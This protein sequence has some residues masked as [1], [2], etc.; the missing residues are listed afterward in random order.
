MTTGILDSLMQLFAVFAAGRSPREAMLGRQSA[1]RYLSGRLSRALTEDYL[2]RYDRALG[3]LNKGM[4]PSFDEVVL[5]KRTSKLS[6]KLL[7]ICSRIQV[8][9]EMKDRLVMFLRLAEF[10]RSSGTIDNGDSFLQGVSD[11]LNLSPVDATNLKALVK[12]ELDV[13]PEEMCQYFSMSFG[14]GI[15]SNELI[16]CRVSLDDMFFIKYLGQEEVRLNGQ[17]LPRAASAPMA[18]G[19]VIKD[20]A[21]HAIFFSDVLRNCSLGLRNEIPVSFAARDVAHFFAYPKEQA[22]RPINLHAEQGELIGIM[23]ASGSGKSTLLNILNGSVQPTFGHVHLN[24][25]SIHDAPEASAGSIGHIAQEDVLIA[26]LSV[27]DNLRYSAA[28]SLGHLDEATI[29][30]Q[31]DQMLRRLGLWEIRDLR[32][33]SFLDKTISGGQRKRVNIALELIREPLVLFVDEPTSGLSSRDSEQIMD[34]LK[35]L[36]L[37]GKLIFVVIHQPSSDIFKLFDRLL[38][39]DYGGFPIYQGNPLESLA[40]FRQLSNHANSSDALCHH[41]GTVNPEELFDTIEA[42]MVD[43]FGQLTNRRRVQPEEWN[44]YYN[45]LYA[46]EIGKGE[47]VDHV[48]PVVAPPNWWK[49][50]K[51]YTQRDVHSKRTNKQYLIINLLEAPVLALILAGFNRFQDGGEGYVYRLSENIPQFLFISVIVSLFMGLSVSAEEILRDRPTLR[52]ERFLQ[53]NWTAYLTSKVSIMFGLSAVQSAVYALIAILVLRIPDAF[54]I[55]F[56]TLFSL[57]CFSNMLGLSISSAFRSAKVIYIIIP[58]LIIPQIIFGG[59]IVRFDRFNPVFTEVDRVPWIGNIMASRWGFESL[60]VALTRDNEADAPFMEIEDRLDRS[61]WRRDFWGKAYAEIS[62]PSKHDKE[63]SLALT[64]LGGWGVVMSDA[65]TDTELV[66]AYKKVYKEAFRDR[67]SL[68]RVLAES[69]DLE[70]LRDHHH[71]DALHSWVMQTDRNGRIQDTPRG[72]IQATGFIHQMPGAK[73]AWNAPFY[74]PFKQLGN[75]TLKTQHFNAVVLWAMVLLL[76]FLLANRI[77]EKMGN[78][79]VNRS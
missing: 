77:P 54:G 65:V 68:R 72:L 34:L 11:A 49:Q 67:D 50:F 24:G 35:E 78:R 20:S 47:T 5:A 32:V 38:L 41:C 61:A 33:G 14:H 23:G 62:N 12:S 71:N 79:G 17:L 57:S 59:A 22:L 60:A 51:V 56:F 9:L 46:Q 2:K 55:L 31:V 30:E 40:H 43:E 76:F 73:Q 63:R 75:V 48:P 37:R 7:R 69:M 64:E 1:N 15:V 18:Q 66:Q 29:E 52:R 25:T 3:E 44:D 26:E 53:L 10:A 19:S 8:E 16:G 36:T 39:L 4:E 45:L 28:L 6:V 70:E 42:R 58:L 21:G 74:A 27:R 13:V